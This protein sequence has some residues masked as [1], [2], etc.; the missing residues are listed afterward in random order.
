MACCGVYLPG[1]LCYDTT[2]R[3]HH[4]MVRIGGY[5]PSSMFWC[6]FWIIATPTPIVTGDYS[7]S[8]RHAA[9]PSMNADILR[10]ML[11]VWMMVHGYG[12]I[13]DVNIG[14]NCLHCFFQQFLPPHS[15][16]KPSVQWF[17]FWSL[18]GVQLTLLSLLMG[19][20]NYGNFPHK[21][22][23]DPTFYHEYH[24]IIIIYLIK[25]MMIVKPFFWCTHKLVYLI[26]SYIYILVQAPSSI[27]AP[28]CFGWRVPF[29][30]TLSVTL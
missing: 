17:K 5:H 29:W 2:G 1:K 24:C 4:V 7:I 30:L 28:L 23:I 11:S 14:H 16:L 25:W 12:C 22:W 13:L 3:C 20:Y 19:I 21:L 9:M 15:P 18:L 8:M 27:I 6:L 26:L 10:L